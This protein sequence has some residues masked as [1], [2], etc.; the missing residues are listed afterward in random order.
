MLQMLGDA[1]HTLPDAYFIS[2]PRDWCQ[3]CNSTG[4]RGGSAEGA[5]AA[6]HDRT[7]G[8]V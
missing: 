6:A 4:V 7:A 5:A 2:C 8:C 3:V 1:S